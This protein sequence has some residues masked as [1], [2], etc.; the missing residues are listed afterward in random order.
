M[1]HIIFYVDE[2]QIS[3]MTMYVGLCHFIQCGMSILL[4][5]D[6]YFTDT[7]SVICLFLYADKQLL[8]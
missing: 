5:A 8:Y 4:A 7:T 2:L 1:S 6:I 3:H